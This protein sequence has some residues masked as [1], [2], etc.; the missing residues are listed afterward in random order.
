MVDDKVE[1]LRFIKLL[2]KEQIKSQSQT[3]EKGDYINEVKLGTLIAFRS[4]EGNLISGKLIKVVKVKTPIDKSYIIESIDGE[5]HIVTKESIAWV[6][7]GQRW[8]KQIFEEL[9]K[10]GGKQNA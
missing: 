9:K 6:K 10:S 3:K 4:D 5:T 1:K 8:P 7:T 2:F